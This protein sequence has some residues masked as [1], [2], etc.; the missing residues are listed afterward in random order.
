MEKKKSNIRTV[1]ERRISQTSPLLHRYCRSN[2]R[3][4]VCYFLARGIL[5]SL[6]ATRRE[7][8]TEITTNF[9]RKSEKVREILR[10]VIRDET[11]LRLITYNEITN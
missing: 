4:P 10:K 8:S 9:D 11:Y 1:E 7:K 5:R 2:E 3:L 6:S